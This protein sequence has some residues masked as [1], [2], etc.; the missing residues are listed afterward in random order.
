MGGD[1]PEIDKRGIMG[2]F[3]E[4][5]RGSG[6]PILIRHLLVVLAFLGLL[7]PARSKDHLDEHLLTTFIQPYGWRVP[8]HAQDV[9][10]HPGDGFDLNGNGILDEAF[11][12][13]KSFTVPHHYLRGEAL[14]ID[15]LA[16]NAKYLH[17]LSFKGKPFAYTAMVFGVHTAMAFR[18]WWM[19]ESGSGSYTKIIYSVSFPGFPAWLHADQ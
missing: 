2:A 1:P 10:T 9:T 7:Q 5:Q 19:D 11:V 14:V 6:L 18:V 8:G 4:L 13:Q 15:D 17:R 3:P 16:V 12:I